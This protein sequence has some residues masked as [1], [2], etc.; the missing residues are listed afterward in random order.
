MTKDNYASNLAIMLTFLFY[1]SVCLC[2]YVCVCVVC[3]HVYTY[4]Y[5]YLYM[6]AYMFQVPMHMGAQ[7]CGIR[8]TPL[9]VLLLSGTLSILVIV[10]GLELTN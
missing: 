2:L 4:A 6:H 1:V 7:A 3:L 5:E 10:S 8:R 9:G